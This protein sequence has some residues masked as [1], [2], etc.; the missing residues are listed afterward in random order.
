MGGGCLS[1]FG[2]GGWGT[3]TLFLEWGV[4]GDP[5]GPKRQTSSHVVMQKEWRVFFRSASPGIK[6]R[7]PDRDSQAGRDRD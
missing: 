4:G 2:Q 6:E 1:G 5:S 3:P 7:H